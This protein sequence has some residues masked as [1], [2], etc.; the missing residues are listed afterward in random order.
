MTD[1]SS[2]VEAAAGIV[3]RSSLGPPGRYRRH[4]SQAD[5]T[6]D[7]YG[8][9]DA[10][11]I[12]YTIGHFPHEPAERAAWVESLRGMQ[13]EAS[14]MYA[15][16]THH[17]IHTTAHCVAALELFD[18]APLHALTALKGLEPGTF[19]ERLPWAED[20]WRA[21]HQGAGI[22]ASL[23]LAGEAPPGWKDAYF[24]WLWDNADPQTGL[25]RRGHVGPVAHSGVSTLMPHLA[26]TFHYLFN[27]QYA[28]RP[29]RYPERLVDTCLAVWRERQF[30]LARRV[31]FAEIDWVY[32]LNRAIR[33]CHHRW[34]DAQAALAAFA[35]EYVAFLLALDPT[36]DPGL[37]D[38]HQLFGVLCALA[39]LQLALPGRLR[40]ERP[41]RLVLDRRPFI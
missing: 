30:P 37:G 36:A 13:D 10:A 24:A 35:D 41:L 29:L 12:L 14:G 27:Q 38:L 34:D 16:A 11:N 31:G 32:C 20:P 40:T 17:T 18:A 19:L 6:Q 2:F 1:L 5:G 7:P 25:L 4:Q 9:A 26:G 8:C 23:V 28:R 22:Y 3:Q 15:E 21:S 33:Q 39:E